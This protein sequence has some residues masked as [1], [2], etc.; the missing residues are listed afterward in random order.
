[1]TVNPIEAAV[2]PLKEDAIKRAE[3]Y[4]ADLVLS[5]VADMD[6]AGWDLKVAAPIPPGTLRRADYIQR[7]TGALK[8]TGRAPLQHNYPQW[9]PPQD[10][11]WASQEYWLHVWPGRMRI[12]RNRKRARLLKRRGVPMWGP[13]DT[14]KRMWCWFV[15]CPY[16][17]DDGTVRCP[18]CSRGEHCET[19]YG[20]ALVPCPKC[21]GKK[22]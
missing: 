22:K 7:V 1:M 5:M 2:M 14:G 3:E 6:R 18:D 16:C 21:R 20:D 4:A 11:P 13:P 10:E 8:R 19:C 17:N 9:E 15:H 12:V